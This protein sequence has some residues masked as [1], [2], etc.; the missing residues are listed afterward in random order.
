VGGKL[1]YLHT[2]PKEHEN[3]FS[4]HKYVYY[5]NRQILTIKPHGEQAITNKPNIS[6]KNK[7]HTTINLVRDVRLK[8]IRSNLLDCMIVREVATVNEGQMS[9]PKGSHSKQC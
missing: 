9:L 6:E 2:K 7:E 4:D 5:A 1:F 3:T 8:K